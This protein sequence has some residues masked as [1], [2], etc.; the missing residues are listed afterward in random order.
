MS[1]FDLP[2]S[3]SELISANQGVANAKYQ[4]ITCTRDVTN[5]N[6]PQGIQQFKW[7]MGGNT[8]FVPDKSY[9]RIRCELK[10]C[11]VNAGG[12]LPIKISQDIS[13][14]MGLA[15]NLFK[16]VQI[17]LNGSTIERVGERM[18]QVDALKSRKSKSKPWMECL[19]RT[20]NMWDY[21][22]DVRRQQTAVDGYMVDEKTWK[23]QYNDGGS[24]I[25]V[26]GGP[27]PLDVLGTLT[28]VEAGYANNVTAAL[29]TTGLLTLGAGNMLIGATALRPGDMIVLG[30]DYEQLE[31]VRVLTATTA[32]ILNKSSIYNTA[33]ADNN[34]NNEHFGVRKLSGAT[35]NDVAHKNSFEL[36]WQPPLGFFDLP[37]AIP[38]NG[39]WTLEFNPENESQ[40]R[41]NAIESL[42]AD[43]NDVQGTTTDA[44]SLVNTYSFAVTQMYLYLYTVE[45]K[46]FDDGLYLLD[47]KNMRCQIE[48]MQN[49]STSL[50]QKN[51]DVSTKTTALTIAFQDQQQGNDTRRSRSKFKIRP[52]LA[53]PHGQE[54]G[55]T[56]FYINYAGM[57]RPQPDF[58]GE[59]T[60]EV[61]TIVDQVDRLQ[62]RYVDAQFQVNAFNAE[63]GCETFMEYLNRGA[64]FYFAWPTDATESSSRVNVN[65]QFADTFDGTSTHQV[66]LFSEWRTAVSIR[67]QGG[68]VVNM[69][70]EEL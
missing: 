33:V 70:I 55:L 18:P 37:H 27:V 2:T 68:E 13:P 1:I 64:Y 54:L 39:V 22:F 46:R 9:M 45:S 47:I 19:G 44:A 42:L 16:S 69:S 21:D 6:F 43:R 41:K 65:Y 23:P 28:Q 61:S 26:A 7:Q 38:P 66:L 58:D 57:Q 50:Q 20:S 63:G 56:R 10:E 40:Y 62:H 52:S 5:N 31:I 15:S 24:F 51:F 17:Q 49:S 11:R 14:N 36:I 25:T 67:V 59:Y 8:W 35:R 30:G 12:L 34:V 4:Q 48:N 60:E 3:A 53:S 29:A 32:I